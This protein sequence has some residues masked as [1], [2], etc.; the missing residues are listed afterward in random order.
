MNLTSLSYDEQLYIDF[1]EETEYVSKVVA[2]LPCNQSVDDILDY[3]E[4]SGCACCKLF[5][6]ME[7]QKIMLVMYETT[8]IRFAFSIHAFGQ[9]P[10]MLVDKLY[11]T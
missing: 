11:A 8:A 5:R 6:A 4:A 9:F 2:C 3:V 7:P 1:N 10:F